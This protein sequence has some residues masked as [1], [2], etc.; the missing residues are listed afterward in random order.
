VAAGFRSQECGVRDSCG[1]L[2]N[3][4]RAGPCPEMCSRAE[5]RFGKE[6]EFQESPKVQYDD[7]KLRPDAVFD[8]PGTPLEL[9][10]W[11]VESTS[12]KNRTLKN[13][14]DRS[15][16]TNSSGLPLTVTATHRGGRKEALAPI[17]RDEFQA[18][19]RHGF[20]NFPPKLAVG[21]H[22]RGVID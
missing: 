11:R 8:M 19:S 15:M 14:K 22:P 21:L 12:K 13:P 18:R 1:G 5:R 6:A 10:F 2:G 7:R 4:E 16:T 17:S 20:S 3:A 9:P